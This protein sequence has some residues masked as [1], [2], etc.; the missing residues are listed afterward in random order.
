M[1]INVKAI[2]CLAL[3]EILE[4]WLSHTDDDM[5]IF[6][7]NGERMTEHVESFLNKIK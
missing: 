4:Q 1:N 2:E 3:K 5:W 7:H 6:D